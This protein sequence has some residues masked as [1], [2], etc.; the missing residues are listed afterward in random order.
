MA[1]QPLELEGT[2]EEILAHSKELAGRRVRVTVLPP[3]PEAAGET[4]PLKPENQRMLE[5]LD[6]W[7]RTP[8]SDEERAILDDFEEH[9]REHR[10]R[11]RTPWELE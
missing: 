3:E 7:E 4:V 6:E 11:L 8:L 9:L 2:W 5:L 1:S 10:F